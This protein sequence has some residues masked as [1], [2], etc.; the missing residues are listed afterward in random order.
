MSRRRQPNGA[1]ASRCKRQAQYHSPYNSQGPASRMSGERARRA[2]RQAPFDLQEPIPPTA[3]RCCPQLGFDSGRG[4]RPHALSGTCVARPGQSHALAPANP[5]GRTCHNLAAAVL[6]PLEDRA[7][8]PRL[9]IA[10]P[11]AVSQPHFELRHLGH[12][13]TGIKAP[14]GRAM[15]HNQIGAEAEWPMNT[16]STQFCCSKLLATV[17]AH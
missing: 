9:L 12:T 13:I 5:R 17:F 6:S 7:L 14:H 11:T 8:S 15:R 4:A 16:T 10:N 2:N 1:S 3:Q